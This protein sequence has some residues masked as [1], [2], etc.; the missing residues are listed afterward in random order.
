MKNIVTIL[1]VCLLLI[2]TSCGNDDDTTPTEGEQLETPVLPVNYFPAA[3][4]NYWNYNVTMNSDMTNPTTA[5]DSLYVASINGDSFML[6]VNTNNI[7]NGTMSNLLANGTL[8]EQ[9]SGALTLNSSIELPIDFIGDG[10]NF[11]GAVLYNTSVPDNTVLFSLS[12]MFTQDV[13]G[14][15]ITITYT[16]STEKV[17]RLPSFTVNNETFNDVE[18]VDFTLELS[19][20]TSVDILGNPT[21]FSILDPQDVMTIRSHYG[22]NIGLLKADSQISFSLNPTTI[23]LLETLN[24]DLN[25]PTSSTATNVEELTSYMIN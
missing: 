2:F 5:T 24:V 22:P 3:L 23:A 20:S 16:L 13:Q 12:D 9:G 21:T 19:V 17:E 11:E 15:P 14:F 25:I 8:T 10:I 18:V 7:A 4:N 1:G 6:D